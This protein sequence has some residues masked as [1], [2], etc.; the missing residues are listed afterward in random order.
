M[1]LG[2]R[3]IIPRTIKQIVR[4][5]LKGPLGDFL[6]S[7]LTVL[8]TAQGSRFLSGIIIDTKTCQIPLPALFRLQL[9]QMVGMFG[10]SISDV[11]NYGTRFL[12]TKISIGGQGKEW[13]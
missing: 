1:M 11:V 4:Y 3:I 2:G 5:A 10:S 9:F 8:R 7:S 13:M 6:P 12:F